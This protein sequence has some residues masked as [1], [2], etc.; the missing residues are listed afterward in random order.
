[1]K[2]QITEQLLHP[3]EKLVNTTKVLIKNETIGESNPLEI[4]V[5]FG[6][7]ISNMEALRIAHIRK[8]SPPP[9][10]IN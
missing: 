2:L 10:R 7:L 5:K 3:D 8:R 1:M 9:I 6:C 4:Q